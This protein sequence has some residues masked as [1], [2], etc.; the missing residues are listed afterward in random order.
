MKEEAKCQAA[1]SGDEVV[2]HVPLATT[3]MDAT[4]IGMHD[5]QHHAT[6]PKQQDPHILE[7]QRGL[8]DLERKMEQKKRS[9]DATL[10]AHGK[11]SYEHSI[12]SAVAAAAK[13]PKADKRGAQAATISGGKS[14]KSAE[15][16][17]NKCGDVTSSLDADLQVHLAK[18][19]ELAEIMSEL[20]ALEHKA[21][22]AAPKEDVDDEAV[23]EDDELEIIED[24]EGEE[25]ANQGCHV[26]GLLIPTDDKALGL[27]Q[28]L[29]PLQQRKVRK[30]ASATAVLAAA[31]VV[32]SSTIDS[33]AI[34]A[35]PCFAANWSPSI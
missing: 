29:E 3:E 27:G 20:E 1:R 18:T 19:A 28:N 11:G 5:E 16:W 26:S 21:Q 10:A 24:E 12:N 7:M 25:D 31:A 34:A 35:A 4:W 2:L 6:Q 8:L 32:L 33:S 30:S 9:L 14:A 22:R 15:H 17:A 23:E 13:E